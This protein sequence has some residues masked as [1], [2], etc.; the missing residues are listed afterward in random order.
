MPVKSKKV[1]GKSRNRFLLL[2]CLF[3]FYF[4]LSNA[5]AQDDPPDSA[6]PPLKLMSKQERASLEAQSDVKMHTRLDLDFME[7]RL[8]KAE[9]LTTSSDYDGM[10]FELGG[11][12]G[13]L[14]NSLDFLTKHDNKSDKFLNNFK[15]L[16]IGLREFVPRLETIRR[17]IPLKYESYVAKL[18][19]YVRDARTKAVEPLFSN[20]VVPAASK[21]R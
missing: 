11:F 1:K 3:T 17:E 19:K 18:V 6:P 12:Q 2:F 21:H 15:K 16:E 8:A 10:F 7:A 20:S 13:L 14:D 5:S 4:L 9:K